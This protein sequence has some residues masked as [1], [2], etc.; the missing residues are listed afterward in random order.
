MEERMV[1]VPEDSERQGFDVLH[2]KIGCRTYYIH[3]VMATATSPMSDIEI[4]N[5]AERL[6][7]LGG[8][9][10]KPNTFSA[11][12]TYNHLISMR[13]KPGRGFAE[14]LADRRWQLTEQARQRIAGG[15]LVSPC[16]ESAALSDLTGMR[17]G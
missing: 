9:A 11:H 14:Q 13:D 2:G 12:I 4:G 1:P 8:Y 7:R 6:A 3:N 5:R 16:I 15:V 17:M 10:C